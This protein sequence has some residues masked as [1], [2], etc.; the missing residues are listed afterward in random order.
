[1]ACYRSLFRLQV[2][3]GFFAG[4]RHSI[5]LVCRAREA[6][7]LVPQ[8]KRQIK[9]ALGVFGTQLFFKCHLVDYL[10]RLV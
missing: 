7:G 8:R 5:R 9:V 6:E 10:F 3:I 4:A 2:V 1:M